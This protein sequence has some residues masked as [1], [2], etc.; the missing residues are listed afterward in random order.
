MFQQWPIGIYYLV[1]FH[2]LIIVN[3][4]VRIQGVKV[5]EYYVVQ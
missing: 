4:M 2:F 1:L 5:M 3:H